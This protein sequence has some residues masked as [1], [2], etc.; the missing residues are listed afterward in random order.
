MDLA[1]SDLLREALAKLG[2]EQ[3]DGLAVGQQGSMEPH[4]AGNSLALEPE[5]AWQ[6][7]LEVVPAELRGQLKVPA[8]WPEWME[9]L[10]P[11]GW[12]V[13]ALGEF[14]QRLDMDGVLD[15]E[16]MHRAGVSPDEAPVG[17]AG[18]SSVV[19]GL[20]EVALLRQAG[21]WEE[22]QQQLRQIP[23]DQET[24]GV[25]RNEEAAL[26]WAQG[27]VAEAGRLWEACG[28]TAGVLYNRGL[29]QRAQGDA[30]VARELFT[31][32]AEKWPEES[33]WHHLARVCALVG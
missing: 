13:H 11:T 24:E 9:S 29:V 14:P 23:A 28:E 12:L 22:A 33:P 30:E 4:M 8:G 16:P 21:R 1:L 25:R 19:N 32:A 7:T 15:G 20:M 18:K 27:K 10:P 5:V 31:R 6:A 3:R 17:L 2:R 26:A